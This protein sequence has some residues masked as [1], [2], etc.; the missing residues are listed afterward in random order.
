MGKSINIKKIFSNILKIPIEKINDNLSTNNCSQW[1]SIAHIDIITSIE[2]KFDINISPEE[3]SNLQ[4]IKKI[5]IYFK[6]TQ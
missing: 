1:D 3:V 5:I 6:K 2:K 4:S